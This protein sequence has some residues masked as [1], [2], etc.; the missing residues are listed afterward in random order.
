MIIALVTE[1]EQDSV[2]FQWRSAWTDEMQIKLK[3]IVKSVIINPSV[4]S[5]YDKE[6]P[7]WDWLKKADLVFVY[8]SRIEIIES[9]PFEDIYGRKYHWNWWALPMYAKLMM[10]P[11][12]KMIAQWDD[13]WIWLFHPDW[14]WWFFDPADRGGPDGLFSSLN[15]MGTPDMVW[16]NLE[17][18]DYIPYLVTPLRYMPIPFFTQEYLDEY[19]APVNKER[20]LVE[21][22]NMH[23]KRIAILRHTSRVASVEHTIHN[24]VEKVELPLLYFSTSWTNP[25]L[26]RKIAE[27]TKEG[28]Y[29]IEASELQGN[30]LAAIGKKVEEEIKHG[31]YSIPVIHILHEEPIPYMRRLRKEAF[32]AIDDAENYIG[33]SRFSMEC[34]INYIP[35]VGSTMASRV[36][37]PKLH[38]EPK[39][40]ARQIELINRLKN[41]REFYNQMADEGH[42][43]CMY[44]LNSERLCRKMIE[45]AQEIGAPETQPFDEQTVYKKEIHRK[46]KWE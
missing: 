14:V 2:W 9:I 28:F 45:Y 44:H 34:A 8:C 23:E 12:A 46:L 31:S 5:V 7:Y 36:F 11:E 29:K 22:Y 24:V 6:S 18:P 10:K 4:L 21:P 20:E 38:T 19:V 39:D 37:F 27:K 35:V 1:F 43:R 33:W 3:C 40:Y 25:E 30:T 32:I 41:D 42:A 15:I 17:N 13:E 26:A 16:T